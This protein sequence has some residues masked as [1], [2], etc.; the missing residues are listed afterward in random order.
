MLSPASRLGNFAISACSIS[1]AS[2]G[3]SRISTSSSSPRNRKIPPF[4]HRMLSAERN[5]RRGRVATLDKPISATSPRSIQPSSSSE[6]R[7]SRSQRD[8]EI[9]HPMR[10][11]RRSFEHTEAAEDLTARTRPT[12]DRAARAS[13]SSSHCELQ[14]A[15]TTPTNTRSNA[16]HQTSPVSMSPCFDA[17]GDQLGLV[18][19][20]ERLGERV[21]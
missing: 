8:E 9:E 15:R 19:V 7:V 18:A 21:V 2:Y 16:S 12:R 20:N 13:R 6:K 11:P 5:R 3:L 10:P 1:S 17:I 4:T 14:A